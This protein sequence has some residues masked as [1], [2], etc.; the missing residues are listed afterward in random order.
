[1]ITFLIIGIFIVVSV[2]IREEEKRYNKI[3]KY[4]IETEIL[5]DEL[6]KKNGIRFLIL[7][8]GMI[9]TAVI[10]YVIDDEYKD[11]EI[12]E[13][14][15]LVS[16]SDKNSIVVRYV[17]ALPEN[18]YK[19][20]YEVDSPFGTESSKEYEVAMLESQNVT[21]IEDP[22]CE[23]PLLIKYESKM[24]IDIWGIHLGG[25]KREVFYV[26]EGTIEKSINLE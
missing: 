13:Q 17:Q 23:I 15:E 24:K 16:L 22:K 3:S 2:S 19:Y 26:P 5:S 9:Y 25:E 20:R 10:S 1:M 14:I 11:W 21:E 4:A 12:K 7:I 6:D 18:V 8:I